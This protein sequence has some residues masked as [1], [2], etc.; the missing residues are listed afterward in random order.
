MPHRAYPLHD[1]YEIC[2]VCTSYQNVFA[3]KMLT[4]LLKELQSYRNFKLRVM[5]SPK[6]L[7][8]PSS[9]IR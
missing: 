7:A 3:V 5:G 8:P 4:D 9:K 1:F 2:R 6:F